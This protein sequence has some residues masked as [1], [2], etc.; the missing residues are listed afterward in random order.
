[1]TKSKHPPGA[2][3]EAVAIVTTS[4]LR[5]RERPLPLR[6]AVGD[7]VAPLP[8]HGHDTYPAERVEQALPRSPYEEVAAAP[9]P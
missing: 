6:C 5:P 3:G 8:G 7:R 9:T 4:Q 2:D 1:M